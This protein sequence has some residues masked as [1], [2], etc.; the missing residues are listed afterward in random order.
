VLVFATVVLTTLPAAAQIRATLKG[1]SLALASL[2]YSPDSRY[3]ATASYD[4]TAKI[5]DAV[6][7]SEI[8]TLRGHEATVEAVRFSPDG[9]ILARGSYDGTVKLWDWASGRELAT[10]RAT[11]T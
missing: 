9:K 7:G 11:P 1:H 3:V 5:W 6:R 8:A 2:D 10:F 4:K